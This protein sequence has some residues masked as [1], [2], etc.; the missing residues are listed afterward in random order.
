MCLVIDANTIPLVFDPHKPGH[1]RFGPVM[2][3][4]TD[5]NGCI[6]YGGTKYRRELKG[7]KRYFRLFG[8]FQRQGRVVILPNRPIDKYAAELKVKVPAKAFDDEHLVAIVAYS[9][10]RVICT[11]D[12]TAYPYLKRQDLYPKHIKRP[13]IYNAPRH[14]KLCCEKNIVDICRK[15]R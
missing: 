12:K 2:K 8:Q 13:K 15:R 4:V 7:M 10:C 6:V 1:I 9:N 11:D 3:W 14:F 5:G